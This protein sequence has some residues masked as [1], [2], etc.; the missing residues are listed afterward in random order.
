[1]GPVDIKSWIRIISSYTQLPPWAVMGIGL[2][3]LLFLF[4]YAVKH[5]AAFFK[6]I[7]IVG[8]F[9]GLGY[10]AYRMVELGLSKKKQAETR[11]PSIL[12]E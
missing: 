6:L 10:V 2:L 7:V 12:K 9:V 3:I 11:L 1:M 8:L 4:I 5:R